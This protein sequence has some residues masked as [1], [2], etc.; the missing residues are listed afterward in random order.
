MEC[1][2]CPCC[3]LSRVH[4]KL[5]HNK[6]EMNVGICVGI[7]IGSIL[8]GIVMLACICHQRKKIRERYGIKGNCCSDCCTA[9]C[10]GGCAIQQHL[11]EMSSMGEFPS[12]CCYTVK[13]GEY[14]T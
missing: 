11:L 1:W 5:K 12:A 4:N 10:C 9:Y 8:I 2:C 14:M 6:A 7:S 13:E 3:Q